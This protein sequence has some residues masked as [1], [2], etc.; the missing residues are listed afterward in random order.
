M[1]TD[2]IGASAI[3]GRTNR[4][5]SPS[6]TTASF[7]LRIIAFK[8]V[9]QV[10]NWIV[11]AGFTILI[12]SNLWLTNGTSTRSVFPSIIMISGLRPASITF[13][14][15]KSPTDAKS[16]G[17]FVRYIRNLSIVSEGSPRN[18]SPNGFFNWDRRWIGN[19]RL[20]GPFQGLSFLPD[21]EGVLAL[22]LDT[23]F[24]S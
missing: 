8:R 2:P 24:F 6:T 16:G 21:L 23:H 20:R 5:S 18:S 4:S 3:S 14:V 12:S 13:L 7:L 15:T 10:S 22:L 19:I 9:F 11:A 1:I 17:V